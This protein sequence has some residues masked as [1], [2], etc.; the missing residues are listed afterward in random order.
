MAVCSHSLCRHGFGVAASQASQ[1]DGTTVEAGDSECRI[2][3][4]AVDAV[5]QAAGSLL[6]TTIGAFSP[7]GYLEIGLAILLGLREVMPLRRLD[8]E[9]DLFGQ[10]V[11]CD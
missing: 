3:L 10:R 2:A 1:F 8:V 9:K 7:F 5:G 11:H 6:H 4:G